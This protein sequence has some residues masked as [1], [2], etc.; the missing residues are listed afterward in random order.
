M[1]DRI[2]AYVD[3][4]AEQIPDIN[5]IKADYLRDQ[6]FVIDPFISHIE[7]IIDNDKQAL[8]QQL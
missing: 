1:I 7:E 8:D 6:A 3:T 2:Y 4:V 5:F